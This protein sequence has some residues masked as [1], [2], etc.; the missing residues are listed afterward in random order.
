MSLL[1]G[2]D[3]LKRYGSYMGFLMYTIKRFIGKIEYQTQNVQLQ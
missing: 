2:V 3:M 1:Q